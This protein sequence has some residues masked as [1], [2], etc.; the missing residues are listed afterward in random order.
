MSRL[1]PILCSGAS[2][3]VLAG[4]MVVAGLAACGQRGPLFLPNDPA[5]AGRPTLPQILI[6]DVRSRPDT[7]MTTDVPP[8]MGTGTLPGTGTANPVPTP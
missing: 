1:R 2:A 8:V 4:A 6:P 3:R 5:A 7:P